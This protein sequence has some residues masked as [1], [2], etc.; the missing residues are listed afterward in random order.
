MK[1]RTFQQI[2]SSILK[3][4]TRVLSLHLIFT[5]FVLM[6][7]LIRYLILSCII[8]S[9]M[10]LP[11]G[12]SDD[13]DVNPPAKVS[14]T[15]LVYM[16]A[17]SNGLGDYA[18]KDYDKQDI[19]EM[20]IA[21]RNGDLNGGRLL[22][23]HSA[24]DGGMVL[25]EITSDGIDTLKIYDRN[26]RSQTTERM[27]EVFEDMKRLAPADDY[28]LILWG[29]GTGW[30]E[31]G[32]VQNSGRKR[33]YGSEHYDRYKMNVTDIA[34]V[35]DGQDFR[36]LYMDCCYMASVEVAYELRHAVPAIVAYS[37]EVLGWGMP[38]DRN[39]KHFF[40]EEPQL[41]D[42]ARQ[43]YEYYQSIS[44][45]RYRMATVS[46]IST[47]GLDRLADA[48]R[49]IY[50][51]YGTTTLPDGYNPQPFMTSATCY[52]FDFASYVRALADAVGD[53]DL[54]D[55]FDRA[56]SDVVVYQQATDKIWGSLDI[57]TH[58]GLSTYILPGAAASTKNGYDRLQWFDDVAGYL[59]N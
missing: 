16:L 59:I 27:S 6:K 12:C 14:R 22:V 52:Y 21:A 28:G 5:N 57:K 9:F 24:S 36:F 49:K 51:N 34:G 37:T 7:K 35:L 29:H 48:T 11:A 25:K 58:S 38:Y 46:V 26:V 39:I 43:T 20:M 4:Y 15:V 1:N 23:Y 8:F 2:K 17:A 42:A 30:I 31:D 53:A 3:F 18:P 44:N 40:A 55:G 41:V 33:S 50:E 10:L 13:Y 45:P 54:R 47:D 32:I 56:M 19:N